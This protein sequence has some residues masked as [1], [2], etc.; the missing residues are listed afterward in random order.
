MLLRPSVSRLSVVASRLLD[1]VSVEVRHF[2]LMKMLEEALRVYSLRLVMAVVYSNSLRML[3][4][5]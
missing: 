2:D 1:L 4:E 3:A 5:I